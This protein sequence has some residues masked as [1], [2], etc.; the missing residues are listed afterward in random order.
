[1]RVWK[2][3][4]VQ[5]KN[6]VESKESSNGV[7]EMR[8]VQLLEHPI[9]CLRRLSRRVNSSPMHFESPEGDGGGRVSYNHRRL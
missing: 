3:V 8:R 6:I 4:F 2:Y 5:A 7:S 1:M 9:S